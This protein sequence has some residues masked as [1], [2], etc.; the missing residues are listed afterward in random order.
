MAAFARHG[1][2]TTGTVRLPPRARLLVVPEACFA[3]RP[4]PG[5]EPLSL[6]LEPRR[7]SRRRAFGE[8]GSALTILPSEPPHVS[9]GM[10]YAAAF[11]I[12]H[13]FQVFGSIC[14]IKFVMREHSAA[15]PAV[16][17]HHAAALAPC[18]RHLSPRARESTHMADRPI[19]SYAETPTS[20]VARRF[21]LATKVQVFPRSG[22]TS[23]VGRFLAHN[24]RVTENLSKLRN[25]IFSKRSLLL[26]MILF[27]SE[28]YKCVYS[29]DREHL[30]YRFQ[31]EMFR[32]LR[33]KF[34]GNTAIINKQRINKI[35]VAI[36]NL[37]NI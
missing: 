7:S 25:F 20:R 22:V 1:P 37:E 30:Q 21:P 8:Y 5:R 34:M 18:R 23:E 16:S 33:P 10:I 29:F 26:V 9:T 24:L 14:K 11:H 4:H 19:S 13:C 17:A 31:F 35:D 2:N 27:Y 6:P 36:K 32:L 12:F 3:V 28:K 15:A